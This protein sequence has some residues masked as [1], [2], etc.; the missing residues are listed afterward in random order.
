M[1]LGGTGGTKKKTTKIKKP[2][3]LP[4]MCQAM[5]VWLLLAL[6]VFPSTTGLDYITLHSLTPPLPRAALPADG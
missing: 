1:P 4:H 5:W 2:S 3:Y 6:S